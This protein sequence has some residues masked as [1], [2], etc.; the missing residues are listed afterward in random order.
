MKSPEETQLSDDLHRIV[1]GQPVAL[2]I[3]AIERSGQRQ[4]RRSLAVRGLAGVAVLGVAV[5]GSL[6]AANHSGTTGSVAGQ[7]AAR[8]ATGKAA[9][10]PASPA[11]VETV[12]YVEKHIAAAASG[13]NN[14][15]VK[16]K[17]NT[18][19]VGTP[20]AEI[21]IWTDPRTGNTMLQQGSGAGRLTYWEH[22]YFDSD[23]VLQS[24][25]T[26]VNYGPRTWWN[27][28]MH[29]DGPIQGPVPSGPV[30]GDYPGPAQVKQWLDAGRRQ[31]RGPPLRRRAP[32][33][34]AVHL[35]RARSRTYVIFADVHTY[36]V[37]RIDQIL[38][39]AVGRPAHH[40]QLP[41]GAADAGHGEAGQQPGDPGRLHP[42]RG[43]RLAAAHP[44]ARTG[45]GARERRRRRLRQPLSPG[46]D[47]ES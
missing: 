45:R 33:R 34:R 30:G 18:S 4:R 20:T 29:G 13:V 27:Y 23:R 40:G 47:F 17:Q 28:D 39:S 25:Q 43:R 36:Q 24:D 31:D 46:L 35:R 15:L 19:S 41:V 38:R 11:K 44:L 10:K 14:Y 12:A 42:G 22:D 37:V 3:E 16:S 7:A 6:A 21:T 9:A 8:T 26:Q 32:H 1:D 5:V 2:D